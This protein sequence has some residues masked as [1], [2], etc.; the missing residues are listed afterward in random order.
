MVTLI[1]VPKRTKCPKGLTTHNPSNITGIEIIYLV[2][3]K[4][5]LP[6]VILGP[7]RRMAPIAG[8][9]ALGLLL[10]T[11]PTS[12]SRLAVLWFC[13]GSNKAHTHARARARARTHAKLKKDVV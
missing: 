11:R 9:L 6:V 3:S 12:S 10:H 2:E 4:V 13:S 1:K 5:S 8:F 7:M